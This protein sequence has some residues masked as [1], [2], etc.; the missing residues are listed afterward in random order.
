MGWSTRD[1]RNGLQCSLG[2]AWLSVPGGRLLKVAEKPSI[3]DVI[4]EPDVVL[5]RLGKSRFPASPYPIPDRASLEM[6][7]SEFF[8]INLSG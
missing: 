4:E 5:S 2:A 3:D 7:G 6:K 1:R 8:S